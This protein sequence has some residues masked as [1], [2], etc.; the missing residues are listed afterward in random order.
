MVAANVTVNNVTFYPMIRKATEDNTYEPCVSVKS[1]I[2][3]IILDETLDVT[4]KAGNI[5]EIKS[6]SNLPK[7]SYMATF[8]TIGLPNSYINGSIY[9]NTV[10]RDVNVSF[11]N[12]TVISPQCSI[13]SLININ[14]KTDVIKFKMLSGVDLTNREGQQIRIVR[15][16]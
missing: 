12:S 7:G 9:V 6:I 13:S 8:R 4:I 11:S 1:N 2:G 3:R 16:V 10:E 5:T 14:S 15:I